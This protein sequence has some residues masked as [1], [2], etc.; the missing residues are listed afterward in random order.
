MDSCE[1]VG[2]G[3][4]LCETGSH[5]LLGIDGTDVADLLGIL[6]S[7]REVTY[8]IQGDFK[9][10]GDHLYKSTASSRALII[11]HKIDNLPRDVDL[12]SFH[13]L[14]ADIDDRPGFLKEMDNPP[15]MAGDLREL[16]VGKRDVNSSVAC[17]DNEGDFLNR[18]G[19]LFQRFFHHPV[20]QPPLFRTR[21]TDD[22]GNDP[23][24]QDHPLRHLST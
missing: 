16:F 23:S 3:N 11:H 2:E 5:L 18:K 21:G 17:S 15:R 8:F 13:I 14:P 4:A 9:S 1:E 19:G 24:V 7:K 10:I 6:A 12:Y 22:G 20:G